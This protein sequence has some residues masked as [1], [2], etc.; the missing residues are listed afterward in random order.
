MS[1]DPALVSRMIQQD[2]EEVNV[3]VSKIKDK[4]SQHGVRLL[5]QQSS[6]FVTPL[7]CTSVFA[8]LLRCTHVLIL[9][10]KC[11]SMF[12]SSL[13][14]T[15]VWVM[16]LRCTSVWVMPLCGSRHWGAHLCGSRHWGAPLCLSSH[17]GARPCG[18]VI[19]IHLFTHLSY[20]WGALLCFVIEVLVCVWGGGGGRGDWDAPVCLSRHCTSTQKLQACNVFSEAQT[21]HSLHLFKVTPTHTHPHPHP[22][23]HTRTR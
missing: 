14:C 4:L 22:P 23:T 21:H 5:L 18:Q 17:W 19:K 3:I 20:L 15:S 2:E 9:S 13:R 16:S 8:M 6:E 1:T 7:R 11:T 12:V 10:L